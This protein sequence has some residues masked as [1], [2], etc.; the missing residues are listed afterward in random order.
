[1]M[2][3]QRNESYFADY[4]KAMSTLYKEIRPQEYIASMIS[5]ANWIV[6]SRCSCGEELGIVLKPGDIC[7]FDFGQ[8]YYNECGYQHFGL[9]LNV[10]C[11]KALV[12]P[13]TSNKATIAK[14]YDPI[15]NP[16]GRKNLFAIGM[17]EGMNKPSVLFVNDIK[18]I[19]TSRTI[20]VIAHMNPTSRQFRDI[21]ERLKV[22]LF[23]S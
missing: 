4:M 17:L 6:R 7:Y 19:N 2:E 10:V 1:M 5:E 20:R 16:Q 14:A 18:S 15:K 13:M 9:V 22:L 3:T 21:Q 23:Q 11:H 8:A 12:I